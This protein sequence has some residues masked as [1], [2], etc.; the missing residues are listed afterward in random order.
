M[1]DSRASVTKGELKAKDPTL[2]LTGFGTL[3]LI[4]VP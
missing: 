4:S 2:L 1:R 3:A